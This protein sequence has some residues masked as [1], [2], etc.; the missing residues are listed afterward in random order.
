M[1]SIA[2]LK[3]ANGKPGEICSLLTDMFLLPCE[4]ATIQYGDIHS[5]AISRLD[6]TQPRP[7][8]VF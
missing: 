8:N 2:E 1:Y 5:S 4:H 6:L 7:M 3:K